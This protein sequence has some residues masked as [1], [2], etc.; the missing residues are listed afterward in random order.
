MFSLLDT[1]AVRRAQIDL[2]AM[3]AR[4][5]ACSLPQHALLRAQIRPVDG[6]TD[7]CWHHYS[8]L[9]LTTNKTQWLA[10]TWGNAR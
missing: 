6:R 4:A 5:F 8:P 1:A 2:L 7:K 9:D 10:Q 3:H